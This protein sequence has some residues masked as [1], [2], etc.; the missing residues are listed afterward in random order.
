M[1]ICN[2]TDLP[3]YALGGV[4][5]ISGKRILGSGAAGIAAIEGIIQEAHNPLRR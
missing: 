2:S 3:V 5:N 4:T 1:K